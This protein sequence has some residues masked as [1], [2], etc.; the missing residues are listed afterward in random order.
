MI[1]WFKRLFQGK[2][3]QQSAAGAPGARLPRPRVG[4]AI[5]EAKRVSTQS[6]RDYADRLQ[7]EGERKGDA[8]LLAQARRIRSAFPS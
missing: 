3:P 8:R 7:S 2:A 6:V 4:P 5:P 1:A